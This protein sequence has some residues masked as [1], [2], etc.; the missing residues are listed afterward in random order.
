MK[1]TKCQRDDDRLLFEL[2]ET[3][4]VVQCVASC[5]DCCGPVG[6][7]PVEKQRL[8]RQGK[9]VALS[10]FGSTTT[11]ADCHYLFDGRCSIYDERPL[12]CRFYGAVLKGV[13]P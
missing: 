3:I 5:S 1:K 4:P 8:A 6:F 10:Q 2:R 9:L 13:I 7:A 11:G 12:V